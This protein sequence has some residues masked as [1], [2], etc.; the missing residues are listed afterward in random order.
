[1]KP[2]P[3]STIAKLTEPQRDQL[4]DWLSENS[5]REAIRLAAEPAPTGFGIT[6]HKTTL[7]RFYK[8]ERTRRHAEQLAEAIST[9]LP[10]I[11]PDELLS[12]A[13]L[14]LLHSC[15]DTAHESLDADSRNQLSR[16]LNRLES[17]Q[18]KREH[19]TLKKQLVAIEQQRL[20]L[21]TKKFEYNAVEAAA[22]HAVQLNTISADD[23]LNDRQK[24]AQ[25][26]DILFGSTSNGSS[27]GNEALNSNAP[28]QQ[29]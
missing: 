22:K 15:Y 18:L 20:D 11:D 26:R 7:V 27:R 25:A 16:A 24:F 13:K 19:L 28:A 4:Y 10:K 29:S 12:Q 1:M 17:A 8:E 21:E 9:D 14:E 5:Y 3:D 23:Q 2:R 6:F